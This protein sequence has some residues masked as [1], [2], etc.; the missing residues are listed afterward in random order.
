MS[1]RKVAASRAKRAEQAAKRAAEKK[2]DK[3][4]QSGQ[5]LF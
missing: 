2:N 5:N 4:L 3:P 1:A